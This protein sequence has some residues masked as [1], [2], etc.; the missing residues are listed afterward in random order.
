MV[1]QY[2]LECDRNFDGDGAIYHDVIGG[3]D[4]TRVKRRVDF[5]FAY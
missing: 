4:S 5:A 3:Y 1:K 2:V